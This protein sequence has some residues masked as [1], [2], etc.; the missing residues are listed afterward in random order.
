[1][2]EVIEVNKYTWWATL[3]DEEKTKYCNHPAYIKLRDYVE[4]KGDV[5][6]LDGCTFY[7]IAQALQGKLRLS[8]LWRVQV[9][10]L[11]WKI[12][13]IDSYVMGQYDMTG[14]AVQLAKD[15]IEWDVLDEYFPSYN[16]HKFFNNNKT[17]NDGDDDDDDELEEKKKE[18][19]V[20]MEY[21]YF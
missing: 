18:K 17:K 3:T 4:S 16:P 9:A 20:V 8:E 2:A 19:P 15:L 12:M 1:M 7:Y 5:R 10:V 21:H 11:D 14:D 13:S 6:T